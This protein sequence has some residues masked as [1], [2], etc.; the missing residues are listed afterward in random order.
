MTAASGP[1]HQD[2]GSR[3]KPSGSVERSRLGPTRGGETK[4]DRSGQTAVCGPKPQL[5]DLHKTAKLCDGLPPAENCRSSRATFRTVR[6]PTGCRMSRS[7]A[8]RCRLAHPSPPFQ[9]T[10][11]L[12]A[13]R[14][15]R[16]L[17]DRLD[18]SGRPAPAARTKL[19]ERVLGHAWTLAAR[20]DGQRR[21][22]A[23]SASQLPPA[24]RSWSARL[25]PAV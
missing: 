6:P 12:T 8:P 17:L 1:I 21:M 5:C 20:D 7:P 10:A 24:I 14:D 3:P 19:R 18:Q 23:T 9:R 11:P 2:H 16:A 4:C 13:H 25:S 15:R 22:A